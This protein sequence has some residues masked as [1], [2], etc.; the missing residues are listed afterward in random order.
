MIVGSTKFQA[1]DGGSNADPAS[2]T[3]IHW[4]DVASFSNA[5]LPSHC[6]VH[7][8]NHA[9]VSDIHLACASVRPVSDQILT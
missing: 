9:T 8:T 3:Q 1:P 2:M 4:T 5:P 7:G 6:S